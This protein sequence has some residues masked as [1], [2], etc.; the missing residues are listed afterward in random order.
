MLFAEVDM[1]CHHYEHYFRHNLFYFPGV[2]VSH[3][4]HI[5]KAYIY[6]SKHGILLWNTS[7]TP[8]LLIFLNYVA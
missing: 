4:S 2:S 8:C 1:V 3:K 5:A 7:Y 6:S